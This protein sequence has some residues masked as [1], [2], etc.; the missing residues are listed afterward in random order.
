MVVSLLTTHYSLLYLTNSLLVSVLAADLNTLHSYHEPFSRPR[1]WRCEPCGSLSLR[2][3]YVW[4]GQPAAGFLFPD[5]LNRGHSKFSKAPRENGSFEFKRFCRQP[6]PPSQS[7]NRTFGGEA[8]NAN[9]GSRLQIENQCAH[10]VWD[11]GNIIIIIIIILF[12]LIRAG[13]KQNESKK[14]HSRRN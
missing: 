3:E 8:W 10:Y 2:S 6:P 7:S 1:L 4:P 11:G 14:K 5:A 12:L 13:K 9:P